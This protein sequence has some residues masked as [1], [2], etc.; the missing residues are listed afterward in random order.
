[1]GEVL[2]REVVVDLKLD[3]IE[4]L[5]ADPRPDMQRRVVVV[6]DIDL[7]KFRSRCQPITLRIGFAVEFGNTSGLP[8][9][10]GIF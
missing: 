2:L 3:I 1:M 7:D 6:R 8:L 5:I 9:Y 10:L 4:P